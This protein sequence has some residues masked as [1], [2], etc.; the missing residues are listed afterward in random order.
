MQDRTSIRPGKK[1]DLSQV[2]ELWC[3][4]VRHH[5]ERDSRLSSVAP[6]GA[7][8]WQRR[9]SNLL[10]DPS[11]RLYVAEAGADRRLVGF[12]TGFLRY[13]PEVLEP[14]KAGNVAD[15]F[16]LPGWRRQRVAWR[17]LVALTRWFQ[18]EKVD[19]IEMS[20]VIRNPAAVNF[21]R[22][23]GAQEYTMQMWLPTGW[24]DS[25]LEGE[26]QK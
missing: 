19:H 9:L 11:C 13:A 10:D 5:V 12:A 15:I 16:V 22:S 25:G 20:M 14:Q 17:L 2:T 23:L 24:Q 3:E 26:D 4:L 6:D 21:W 18:E 1:V 8:K 7:E